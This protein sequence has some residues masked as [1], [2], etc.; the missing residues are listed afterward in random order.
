[1]IRKNTDNF[2][3]SKIEKKLKA[4]PNPI[5][6]N[7]LF[8]KRL[9]IIRTFIHFYS[10]FL[11]FFPFNPVVYESNL[12]FKLKLNSYYTLLLENDYTDYYYDQ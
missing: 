11:I 1:M 6:V 4:K 7:Y 3:S 10:I 9:K 2:I 8:N 5:N 12:E